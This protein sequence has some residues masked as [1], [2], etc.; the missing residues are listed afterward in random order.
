MTELQNSRHS[1]N[2]F[3]H[4]FYYFDSYCESFC[5][6][7]HGKHTNL[8]CLPPRKKRLSQICSSSSSK[9]SCSKYSAASSSVGTG[10]TGVIVSAYFQQR[11]FR[12]A[13]WFT[14]FVVNAITF[15]RRRRWRWTRHFFSEKGERQRRITLMRV[16]KMTSRLKDSGELKDARFWDADGNRKRTF[17]VPGQWCVTYVYNN[18]H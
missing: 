3:D 7:S 18:H 11:L 6:S 17:R 2:T 10:G 16:K 12:K 9:E 1:V 5:I 15:A 14:F 4:S 8:R 13:L